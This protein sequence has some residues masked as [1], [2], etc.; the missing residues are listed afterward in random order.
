MYHETSLI[1][2]NNNIAGKLYSKTRPR[3][4]QKGVWKINIVASA[5]GARSWEVQEE[6]SNVQGQP[7]GKKEY[8]IRDW[9][10]NQLRILPLSSGEMHSIVDWL[11]DAAIIF[12]SKEQFVQCL[13]FMYGY[14]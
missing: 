1:K 9:T 7:G 6:K 11:K 5:Q 10:S 4:L 13:F 14:C 12:F 3:H 8:L 2:K